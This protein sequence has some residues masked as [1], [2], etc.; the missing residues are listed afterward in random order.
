MSAASAVSPVRVAPGNES[1]RPGAQVHANAAA[2]KIRAQGSACV[3]LL[4][5]D[6]SPWFRAGDQ[7]FVRRWDFEMLRPGDV[8]LFERDEEF[9]VHRVLRRIECNGGTASAVIT[10]GDA[11]DVADD[12][13]TAAE[14]LGR[15]RRIHR[16]KRHIDIESLGQ[17]IVARVLARISPVSPIVYA[18]LRL[19][20][21]LFS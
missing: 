7:V 16:R 10:K 19:A 8:I 15:A 17:A 11:L 9:F 3:R 13:V 2:A 20:K 1:P 12:P 14:F 18:P 5:G 6:M 4:N 21:R